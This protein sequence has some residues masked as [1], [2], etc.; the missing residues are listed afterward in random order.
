MS[1]NPSYLSLKRPLA[2]DDARDA[3]HALAEQRRSAE[4]WHQ[5]LTEEA[6]EAERDYRKAYADAY[7][8][9]EGTAPAR[10]AAAK[11]ETADKAYE[12]D[13]KAGMVKVA[14]ERLRG[15]EGERSMLKSLVE[16]SARL[17]PV[18]E[19]QPDKFAPVTGAAGVWR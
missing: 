8:S 3:A 4:K 16:W 7:M 1:N 6:A 15:L 19:R 17:D 13:L 5:D 12:R 11:K 2:M 18:A 14:A 10:E 9:A